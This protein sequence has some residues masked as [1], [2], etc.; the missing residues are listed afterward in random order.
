MKDWVIGYNMAQRNRN[1]Q[2]EYSV[3]FKYVQK[4]LT[5]PK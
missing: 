2:I 5:S 1:D 4:F 3:K